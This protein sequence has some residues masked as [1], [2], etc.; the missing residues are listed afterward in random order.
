MYLFENPENFF[1]PEIYTLPHNSAHDFRNS[2]SPRP[3]LRA[4]IGQYQVSFN[5]ALGSDIWI[6]SLVD[7]FIAVIIA[8]VVIPTDKFSRGYFLE[9]NSKS[10]VIFKT[11]V[12]SFASFILLFYVYV[13]FAYIYMYHI[14]TWCSQRSDPLRLELWMLVSHRV[15]TG[16]PTRILWTS[17]SHSK[18]L[19][20]LFSSGFVPS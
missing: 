19:S 18:G 9:I 13:W 3:W 11:V 8:E 17:S 15:G 1:L 4:P 2:R 6:T 5:Q 14:C 20:H 12:F 7:F 16:R 10:M